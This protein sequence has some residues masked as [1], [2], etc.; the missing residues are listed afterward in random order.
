MPW[1]SSSRWTSAEEI[2]RV[3]APNVEG[4]HAIGRPLAALL[5]T[6]LCIGARAQEPLPLH[7]DRIDTDDGIPGHELLSLHEDRDGF[8]WIGT[9]SGLA[10]HEGVRVRTFHHDRKDTTS[11]SYVVNHAKASQVDVRQGWPN[12]GA[13]GRSDLVVADDGIGL[14]GGSGQPGNGLRN[15]RQHI[16]ALGGTVTKHG[17]HGTVVRCQV[18]LNGVHA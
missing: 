1:R 13:G 12:N 10:R 14:P 8:I 15:I 16:G 7:F 3:Q 4:P 9:G 11:L 2:L 6:C 5:L 18:P 17:K